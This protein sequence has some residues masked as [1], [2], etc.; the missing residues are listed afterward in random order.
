MCVCVSVVYLS[1]C[2]SVCLSHV[3]WKPF[4]R[5]LLLTCVVT[6]R[7]LYSNE[8]YPADLQVAPT[9]DLRRKGRGAVAEEA[10]QE[11]A[12]GEEEEVEEEAVLTDD[13]PQRKKTRRAAAK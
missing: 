2:L 10:E 1:V 5:S 3:L 7:F 13:A 8:Y 4:Q 9:Q 11:P 12:V 6:A